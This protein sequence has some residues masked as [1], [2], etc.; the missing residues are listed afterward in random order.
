MKPVSRPVGVACIIGAILFWIYALA[1]SDG[2]LLLDYVNLP[3]H[4][5]GHIFFGFFGDTLGVWGGTLMQLI[6]PLIVFVSFARRGDTLGMV[7]AVFWFGENFLNIGVYVGDAKDMILPLVGG[8]E[9]DWN[10]IL[11]RLRLVDHCRGIAVMLKIIGW[12]IM[13]ASILWL[14]AFAFLRES[15]EKKRRF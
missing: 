3:F 11:S 14:A 6:I 2:F 12:L 1:D 13:I 4:E 10:I 15:E 5:F 9:H 7:F 8:G